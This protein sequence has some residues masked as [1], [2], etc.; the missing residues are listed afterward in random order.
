MKP[1]FASEKKVQGLGKG[2]C[3]IGSDSVPGEVVPTGACAPR[4][5]VLTGLSLETAQLL[6][7]LLFLLW[8]RT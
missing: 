7:V 2:S 3:F 6:A 8:G 1:F 5:R 4:D